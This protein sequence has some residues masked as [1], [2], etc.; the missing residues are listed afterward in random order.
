MSKR[1][2]TMESFSHFV[3]ALIGAIAIVGAVAWGIS[4]SQQHSC[5]EGGSIACRTP[6][7]MAQAHY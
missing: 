6:A 7:Q 3:V 5:G 1:S 2:H 4:A